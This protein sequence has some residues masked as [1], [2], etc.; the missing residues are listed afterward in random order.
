MTFKVR[1]CGGE[2]NF[3][4]K[5]EFSTHKIT[6]YHHRYFQRSLINIIVIFNK[7]L[8]KFYFLSFKLCKSEYDNFFTL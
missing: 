4:N 1:A 3:A 8:Y 2:F 7:I 6:N 5:F